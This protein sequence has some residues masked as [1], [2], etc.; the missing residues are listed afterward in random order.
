MHVKVLHI[1]SYSTILRVGEEMF[2][3]FL[4]NNALKNKELKNLYSLIHKEGPLTTTDLIEKT[5]LKK[6]T[7]LRMIDELLKRKFIKECGFRDTAVGRPPILYDVEKECSYIIGI[8]I[9]RMKTNIVLLNLRFQVVDQKSYVMTT[10]HTPEFVIMKIQSTINY[11]KEKHDFDEMMLLGIGLSAIGPIEKKKGM[12]LKPESFLAN[13]WENVPI[14]QMLQEKIPVKVLLEKAANTAAIAEY[15]STNFLYEKILFCVSGGW[16][17]DCGII[18]GGTIL[19]SDFADG[20]YGHMIINLNGDKCLCGKRGCI[21]AYTSFESIVNKLGKEISLKG[22]MNEDLFQGASLTDM[23]EFFKQGDEIT[24][25][26]IMQSARY[27]GVGLSNLVN[28]FRPELVIINGPFI[29][30]T[31]NYYEEVVEHTKKN[32]LNHSNIVFSQGI[33]KENAAA[34]GVAI[35]LYNS[36]FQA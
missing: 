25:K 12:I 28:L 34:I 23:M 16:G 36:Y 1:V 14:V 3:E 20:G 4:Q 24:E 13:S 8:H 10:M 2:K 11:F 33:L 18:D 9:S 26:V 30:E 19:Q 32:T 5:S 15:H 35:L 31:K 17:M 29:F 22:K 21:L 7:L 27:L 6:T